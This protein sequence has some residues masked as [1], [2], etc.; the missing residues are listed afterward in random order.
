[1]LSI[2]SEHAPFSRA[3]WAQHFDIECYCALIIR[4]HY[5]SN[6]AMLSRIKCVP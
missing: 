3:L 1:M 2:P 4:Q 5:C 6:I